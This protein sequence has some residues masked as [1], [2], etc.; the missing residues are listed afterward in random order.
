M[1][2]PIAVQGVPIQGQPLPRDWALQAK[3]RA[4]SAQ[5]AYQSR[6][7]N[8]WRRGFEGPAASAAQA[9]RLAPGSNSNGLIEQG[10]LTSHEKPSWDDILGQK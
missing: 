2:N 6:L 8:A 1:K 5:A 3:Q 4:E 7:E 10:R 9:A